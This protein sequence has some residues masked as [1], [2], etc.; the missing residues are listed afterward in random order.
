M[1]V[2]FVPSPS[3]TPFRD[4][5]RRQAVALAVLVAGFAVTALVALQSSRLH[6]EAELAMFK[7]SAE[8]RAA[9][10]HAILADELPIAGI[11]RV[12]P[13][14]LVHRRVGGLVVWDGWFDVTACRLDELPAP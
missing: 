12:A 7:E 11:V 6:G 1:A 3:K 14:G 2:R 5:L 13:Q 8:Q 9:R 4:A 10:V